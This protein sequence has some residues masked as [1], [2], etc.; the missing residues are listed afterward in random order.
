MFRPRSRLTAPVVRLAI[1]P[2]WR[3]YAQRTLALAIRH[4]E[5]EPAEAG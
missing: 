1:A 5:G 3:A 4:A 2:L